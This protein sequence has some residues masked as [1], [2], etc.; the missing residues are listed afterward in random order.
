M[1]SKRGYVRYKEWLENQ[2][3]NVPTPEMLPTKTP[4]RQSE[5][6]KNETNGAKELADNAAA[7]Y[8][9]CVAKRYHFVITMET[10]G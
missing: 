2:Q 5:G 10:Q 1:P 3:L 4:T 8:N 7:Y 6:A 9:R